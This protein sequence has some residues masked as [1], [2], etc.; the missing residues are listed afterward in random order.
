MDLHARYMLGLADDHLIL[1][2]RLCAWIG[3][4]PQLEEELA[5]ANIGLDLIGQS[6][7]LYAHVAAL[8]GTGQTEDQIALTREERAYCNVL[9]VEQ[10]NG[11]FAHTMVRQ[12]FFSALM[13]PLWAALRASADPVLSG[14]AGQAVKE[15]TYHI[16]HSGQWII[17]LGDG[18]AESHRRTQAAVD[19]LWP[20]V[21]ELFDADEATHH[22]IS[23]GV[24]VDPATVR[25]H[26]EQTIQTVFAQGQL[27]IPERPARRR[28]GR[29]GRHTEHLGRL[30]CELQYMQRS[31]PGLAW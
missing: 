16:R 18:T 27:Q 25:G 11:D 28:G 19:R 3:N 9:L 4:A 31:Y 13:G 1:A 29:A 30:L 24:G 21:E 12:L 15:V 2:Q 20:F 14:V 22:A 7:P 6:R 23:T 8:N 10:P 26:W 5:I 17:R